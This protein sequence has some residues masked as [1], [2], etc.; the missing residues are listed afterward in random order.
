M[1]K[2]R[3]YLS[4]KKQYHRDEKRWMQYKVEISVI[5]AHLLLFKCA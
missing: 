1:G 2:G 5:L 3:L 4:N